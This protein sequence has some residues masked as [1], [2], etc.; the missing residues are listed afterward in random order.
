MHNSCICFIA[1]GWLPGGSRDLSHACLAGVALWVL[2]MA[3]G[4]HGAS[5]CQEHI[6]AALTHCELPIEASTLSK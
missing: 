3:C 6:P 5:I 4:L 2:S 1:S